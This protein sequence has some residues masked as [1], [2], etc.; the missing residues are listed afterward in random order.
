MRPEH[1]ASR[2]RKD[3][4]AGANTFVCRGYADS[5]VVAGYDT[6][7]DFKKR[8]GKVDLTAFHTDAA[9]VAITSGATTTKLWVEAAPGTFNAATDL[10]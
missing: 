7:A 4:G 6:I 5:N 8:I 9:H 10:F 3:A 1:P 2:T